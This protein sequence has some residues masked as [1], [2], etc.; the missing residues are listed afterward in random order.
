[1]KFLQTLN[2]VNGAIVSSSL[3]NTDNSTNVATTAFVK[4]QGYLTSSTLPI[5]TTGQL[6]VIKVGSNLTVDGNGVLSATS[7]ASPVLTPTATATSTTNYGSTNLSFQRSTWNGTSAV[8]STSNMNINNLGVLNWLNESSTSVFS[9]DQNGQ[10][11]FGG[12]A[13]SA[14]NTA[15]RYVNIRGITDMGV[16]ELAQGT[17]ADGA[18]VMTGMIQI[19]DSNNTSSEKRVSGIVGMTDPNSATANARGGQLAFYTR[20]DG[21]SGTYTAKMTIGM[22]GTVKTGNNTLDD[23]SGNAT[24]GSVTIGGSSALSSNNDITS[25]NDID[26]RFWMGL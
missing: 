12:S 11:S 24:F 6:G 25:T 1:M 21:T 16:L 10:A 3:S 7:G 9:V 23:G 4:A 15:R 26:C 17:V 19:S 20:T 2:F 8:I 14:L 5:A 13:I 22:S 18:N